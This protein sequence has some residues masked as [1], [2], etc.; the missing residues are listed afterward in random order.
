MKNFYVI[1]ALC[2]LFALFVGF[3]NFI[4]TNDIQ[5]IPNTVTLVGIDVEITSDGLKPI[6]GIDV[7]LNKSGLIVDMSKYINRIDCVDNTDK[8]PI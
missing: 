2:M 3:F 6:T 4:P 5:L 7:D 1:T 8:I